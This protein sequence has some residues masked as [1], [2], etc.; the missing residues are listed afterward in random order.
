MAGIFSWHTGNIENA[1]NFYKSALAKNSNC[2]GALIGLGWLELEG[3]GMTT[4]FER[5]LEKSMRD[6]EVNL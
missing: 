2:I 4:F 5:A 6:I 3:K 1:S